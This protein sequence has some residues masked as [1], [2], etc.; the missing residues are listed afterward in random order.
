MNMRVQFVMLVVFFVC[1]I[2][3]NISYYSGTNCCDEMFADGI[4][5]CDK[6]SVVQ[7]TTPL[8][9]VSKIISRTNDNQLLL[10]TDYAA[11]GFNT[12]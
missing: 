8:C 4:M 1:C 5:Y 10:M 12:R 7:F 6:T 9:L 3:G 2:T 11:E